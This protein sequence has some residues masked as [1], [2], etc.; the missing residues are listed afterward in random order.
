[1]F[2]FAPDIGDFFDVLTAD[3]LQVDLDLI[4]LIMP[5]DFVAAVVTLPDPI[6][7]ETAQA[8]RLTFGSDVVGVPEPVTVGLLVLGLLA[9]GL[10]RRKPGERPVST[11]EAAQP[12]MGEEMGF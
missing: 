10:R 9:L 6:R 4:T 8:L 12:L 5:T 1:M 7:G 3:S 11:R 2:G